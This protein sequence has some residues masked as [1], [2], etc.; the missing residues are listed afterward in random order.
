MRADNSLA[1]TNTPEGKRL[2]AS[3]NQEHVHIMENKSMSL[4]L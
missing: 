3:I 2:R 1:L 4:K